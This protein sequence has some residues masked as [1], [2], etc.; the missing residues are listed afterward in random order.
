MDMV[1]RFAIQ[2][3]VEQWVG[4]AE[5]VLELFQTQPGFQSAKVC[6]AIDDDTTGLIFLHFDSIGNYRRA[7]SNY[8]IKLEATRFL[9]QAIDESSAFEV[10]VSFT[11]SEKTHFQ[12]EKTLDTQ[13]IAL[14]DAATPRA[15]SRI[16]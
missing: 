2:E 9:S 15:Q 8:S 4:S 14:G 5:K 1:L 7:L 13:E 6:M 3:S 16:E 11:P 12:S 10:L